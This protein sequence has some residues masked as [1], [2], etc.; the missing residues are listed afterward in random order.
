MLCN[1]FSQMLVGTELA[2]GQRAALARNY[3]FA[4]TEFLGRRCILELA[5]PDEGLGAPNDTYEAAD[6]ECER[7][8]A[9]KVARV[10]LRALSTLV[11]G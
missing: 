4:D 11:S 7:K 3:R 8:H 2:A 9:V 10:W 1:A 5:M 6:A